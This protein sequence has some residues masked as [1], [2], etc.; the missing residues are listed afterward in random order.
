MPKKQSRGSFRLTPRWRLLEEQGEQAIRDE[1]I[2]EI[3]KLADDENGPSADKWQ[4][5][6][7]DH[8]PASKQ[9]LELLDIKGGWVEM[10]NIA[11]LQPASKNRV[12]MRWKGSTSSSLNGTPLVVG[13]PQDWHK[14]PLVVKCSDRWEERKTWNTT[15]HRYEMVKVHKGGR[16]GFPGVAGV[17]GL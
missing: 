12:Q 7:P 4:N 1:V 2:R 3:R 15:L 13:V 14:R 11:G 8:L 9:L 16:F 17:G 6:R 5:M 10:L